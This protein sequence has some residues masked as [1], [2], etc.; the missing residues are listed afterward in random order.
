[1]RLMNHETKGK[2]QNPSSPSVLHVCRTVD[3]PQEMM[4]ELDFIYYLLR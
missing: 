4:T 1:M 3:G 2:R